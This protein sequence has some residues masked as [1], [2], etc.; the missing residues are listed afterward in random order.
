[1]RSWMKLMAVAALILGG[2]ELAL[3]QKLEGNADEQAIR[4]LDAEW[5]AAA[6]NKDV[7]KSVSFYAEDGLMLPSNAPKAAGKAQIRDLWSHMVASPGFGVSFGPTKIEVAKSKDMAYE[8]GTY[9][10]TVND[11]QATPTT[12]LGKYVVVWQKQSDKQWKV[13]ADIFNPDK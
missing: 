13:V 9:E 11:P 2:I 6:Q 4:K 7:E 5:S 10:M 1:M 12:V 8:V 3:G